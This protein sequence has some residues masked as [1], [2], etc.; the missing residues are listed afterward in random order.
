MQKERHGLSEQ[1]YLCF[2]S[3][4]SRGRHALTLHG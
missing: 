1:A 4:F 2:D 3:M